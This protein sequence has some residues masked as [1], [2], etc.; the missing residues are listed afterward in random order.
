L[1][2]RPALMWR[3]PS[4]SELKKPNVRYKI[5]DV[6]NVS[7]DAVEFSAPPHMVTRSVSFTSVLHNPPRSDLGKAVFA[8]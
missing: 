7:G 3:A 5:I 6:G 1:T 8:R 4:R 2:T